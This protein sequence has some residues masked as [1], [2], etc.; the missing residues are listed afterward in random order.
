M[1]RCVTSE[2][3]RDYG[4][5]AFCMASVER[6]SHNFSS[7]SMYDHAERGGESSGSGGGDSSASLESRVSSLNCQTAAISPYFTFDHVPLQ[8]RTEV[9]LRLASLGI[10]AIKT[11]P[12]AKKAL[13]DINLYLTWINGRVA[14]GGDHISI[15]ASRAFWEK[16]MVE[17]RQQIVKIYKAAK[18]TAPPSQPPISVP[19][20]APNSAAPALDCSWMGYID[21]GLTAM[22]DGMLKK[23][24]LDNKN[25]FTDSTI[26]G[27]IIKNVVA[28]HE[29]L[30]LDGVLNEQMEQIKSFA[31]GW[32]EHRKQC[33][34]RT[35]L[36]W[37]NI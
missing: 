26:E 15:R 27:L 33:V 25:P 14:Y 5:S 37:D 21:A 18:R 22:V 13:N 19:A 28:R 24:T 6:D 1:D 11:K 8:L 3:I 35:R 7:T 9:E 16:K 4:S 30:H 32:L 34:S 2:G 20:S 17:V 29:R 36:I 12:A 10:S 23:N 31:K